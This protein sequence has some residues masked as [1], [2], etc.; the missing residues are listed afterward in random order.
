MSS[1]PY[2][3]Y[4]KPFFLWCEK[5]QCSYIVNPINTYSNIFYVLI[6]FLML[7][8][9]KKKNISLTYFFPYSSILIGIF[10]SLYHATNTKYFHYLD[11][12]SIYSFILIPL[13]INQHKYELI[14]N[15]NYF[16]FY[17][18]NK[19]KYNDI[20]I[21]NY[22]LYYIFISISTKLL[23]TFDFPI[24][25][26]TFF[27][28][29]YLVFL[30]M[31]LFDKNKNYT[32]LYITLF[33]LTFGF[34]FSMLDLSRVICDDTSYFQGHALWHFLSATSIYFCDKYYSSNNLEFIL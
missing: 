34:Y 24:P 11:I 10:S 8:N 2:D 19:Y 16:I 25:I 3:T 27:L 17:I 21:F 30:E 15:K 13:L 6:G 18:K 5:I 33:L 28:I 14:Y 29:C 31:V 4:E 23:D 26:I 20:L 32:F 7:L 9:K 22:I 1:C 12:I